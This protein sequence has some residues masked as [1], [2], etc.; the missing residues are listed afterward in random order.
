MANRQCFCAFAT[1]LGVS[2]TSRGGGYAGTCMA[3]VRVGDP[4]EDMGGA[5][6]AGT[7]GRGGT[8]NE[9]LG[10]PNVTDSVAGA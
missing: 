6:N 10:E 3:S 5:G 2:S 1:S 7:G 4:M 8:T 9:A